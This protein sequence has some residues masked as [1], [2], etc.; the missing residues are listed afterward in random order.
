MKTN[1]P[2]ADWWFEQHVTNGR[3][4]TDI[5]KELGVS[6]P[7]AQV[8]MKKS[9]VEQQNVR[10]GKEAH[11][12]LNDPNWLRE[13]YLT[14]RRTI[15]NIAQELGVTHGTV[16][17]YRDEVHKIEPENV[18][19]S[20][21]AHSKLND[22]EW[23]ENQYVTNNHSL[24]YIAQQ[25]SVDG[26]T[27]AKYVS[28][29]N[30]PIRRGIN[31]SAGEQQVI[32]FIAEAGVTNIVTNSHD[33]IHPYELDVYLPEFNLAIE[34]CGLYWHSEKHVDNTYH[35]TKQRMCQKRG[36]R[37]LTIFED[38]WKQNIS[39]VKNKI[40]HAINAM[41]STVCYARRCEIVNVTPE[42]RRSFLTD[43]HIQGDRAGSVTLGL[44]HNH[45]IVAVMVF[46]KKTT[47]CWELV[48]YATANRVVGGFSKL[49]TH[50]KTTYQWDKIISFADLRY[51]TGNLYSSLGWVEEARLPPDYYWCKRDVKYHKFNFRHAVLKNK[52][53]NYDPSLSEAD[54]CRTNGWLKIYDCGKIRYSL[55]RTLT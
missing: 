46:V 43:N 2:T 37:L 26:T 5:A 34:Y 4:L 39:Q 51:S 24:T 25:L 47:T 23:L 55:T 30:I 53:S 41:R 22:P 14:K 32:D 35:A 11:A 40:L 13:Q 12:L 38:E 21:E 54:N 48:R 6:Y 31:S 29:L 20:A 33:I 19:L 10:I 28:N 16:R 45:T 3:K 1:R 44:Q 50:F 36:I 42:R 17:L 27:V 49:L 52:L 9:G 7:T 8:W 18:R 15:N